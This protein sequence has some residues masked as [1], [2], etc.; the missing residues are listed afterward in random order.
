MF[1]LAEKKRERERE[2]F[3]HDSAGKIRQKKVLKIIKVVFW[4]VLI[5]FCALLLFFVDVVSF[6][7]EEEQK[8]GLK[9][10]CAVVV[11]TMNGK[12]MV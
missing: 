11:A 10:L 6:K 1:F 9:L 2:T 3:F 12:F 5:F 8:K 7:I 4:R